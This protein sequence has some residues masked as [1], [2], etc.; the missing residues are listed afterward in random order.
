MRFLIAPLAQYIAKALPRLVCTQAAC[1]PSVELDEHGHVGTMDRPRERSGLPA[2]Y[3]AR[4]TVCIQALP[5][6]VLAVC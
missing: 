4:N 1:R 3:D 6:A 5:L 2:A